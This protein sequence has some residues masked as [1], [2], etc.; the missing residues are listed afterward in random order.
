MAGNLFKLLMAKGFT[1]DPGGSYPAGV[2]V[3]GTQTT[4]D[5]ATTSGLATPGSVVLATSGN[6]AGWSEDSNFWYPPSGTASVSDRLFD[7]PIY[8]GSGSGT[9]TFNNCK[10]AIDG[11]PDFYAVAIE[12]GSTKVLTFNDCEF[13]LTNCGRNYTAG[14]Y[15]GGGTMNFNRCYV[16]HAALNFHDMFGQAIASTSVDCYFYLAGQKASENGPGG[17]DN[18][19]WEGFHYLI[20]AGVHTRCR[21]QLGP[22]STAPNTCTCSYVFLEAN[23]ANLTFASTDCIVDGTDSSGANFVL[24]FGSDPFLAEI[25]ISNLVTDSGSSGVFSKGANGRL[26]GGPAYDID[27]GS[28][29]STTYD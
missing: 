19:H 5:T 14:L 18:D 24:P 22:A 28:V 4:Y 26:Y 3:A 9:I 12:A 25:T 8:Q 23:D 2:V 10:S 1:P 6:M 13:D 11:T 16:H 7:K 20:G 21:V 15:Q 29:I 27:T 17:G